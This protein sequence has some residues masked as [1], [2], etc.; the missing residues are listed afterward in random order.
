MVATGPQIY[1]ASIG[2][3]DSIFLML[4]ALVVFGPR[5]L[6]EIGRQIGKLMYEFRKVSNDFKFQMEE[7]L[8]THEEAERQRKLQAALPLVAPA[9]PETP[10]IAAPVETEAAL[11][12][13][14]VTDPQAAAELQAAPEPPVTAEPQAAAEQT[15]QIQPPST[16]EQVA[17]ARPFRASVPAEPAVHSGSESGSESGSVSTTE[18]GSEIQPGV[19]A[20]TETHHG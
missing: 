5:R 14:T 2:I 3:Q 15:I 10:G 13:Q 9:V 6:P 18:S 19:S 20:E 8:R 12:P 4:L 7:E 16:G 11:E 17:A 1:A